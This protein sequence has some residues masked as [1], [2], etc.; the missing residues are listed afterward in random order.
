MGCGRCVK[1]CEP[2][3][4]DINQKEELVE[5]DV[6]AII[7]ATGYH[8]FDASRKPEYGYGIVKNVIT[9]MELEQMLNASGPTQGR[10]VRPSDGREAK[11]VAFIQCVGS[12][13]ETVG[14]PYCSRVCCM[15]AIKNAGFLMK[16]NPEKHMTVNY[17][18]IKSGDEN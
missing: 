4:I 17:I 11:R 12:R 15:A 18:D 9:S 13:D 10:L 6:G 16:R 1:D 3:D 2:E 5:F 14:N 7:V 8:L